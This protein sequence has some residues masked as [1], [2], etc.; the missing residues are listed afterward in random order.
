MAGG[1]RRA[2]A[3]L[4]RRNENVSGGRGAW[5]TLMAQ[6]ICCVSE[7]LAP[8]CRMITPRRKRGGGGRAMVSRGG[9]GAIKPRPGKASG[10]V[11]VSNSDLVGEEWISVTL[12]NVTTTK[13]WVHAR[14]RSFGIRRRKRGTGK[15]FPG[16]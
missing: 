14:E 3:V 16:R 11:G 1:R 15:A 5:L 2:A 9:K 10:Y 4:A 8:E 13:F 7:G 6:R 12:R